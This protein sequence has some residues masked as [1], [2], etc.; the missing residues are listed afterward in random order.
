MLI[1]YIQNIAAKG[2]SCFSFKNV[3]KLK[4]STPVAVG[5][6]LRFIVTKKQDFGF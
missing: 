3:E 6:A 5:A 2:R 4:G 1:E